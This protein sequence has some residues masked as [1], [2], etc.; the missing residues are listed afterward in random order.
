MPIE[1]KQLS[2]HQLDAVV[3]VQERCYTSDL[4]ENR[5]CFFHK[6]EIFPN[7]CIGAFLDG[8]LVGYAFFHPWISNRPVPLND[9]TYL[10]PGNSNCMY[11]HD[12]AV[13]PDR[14]D[15]KCAAKLFQ[16][17]VETGQKLSLHNFALVAVQQSESYW[18]RWGFVENKKMT[19]G[20]SA[21]TYMICSGVP[22]WQ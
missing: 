14:R 15:Q 4:L 6:M 20:E 3:G 21:A 16:Q 8:E 1:I 22:R 11:I 17:V 2:T 13:L 5:M 10:I 7:G 9:T 19:Y 12:V 18:K